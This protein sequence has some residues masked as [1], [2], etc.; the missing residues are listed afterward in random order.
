[1][2]ENT[3]QNLARKLISEESRSTETANSGGRPA[4]RVCEKLRRPLSTLAGAAGFRSLAARALTLAK[5]EDSWLE[6]VTV[7]PDGSFEFTGGIVAQLETSKAAKAGAAVV[8]RLLGL[9]ITFIGEA[10]TIR[11]MHDV[12]PNAALVKL[13]PGG[14]KP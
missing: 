8:A 9:L 7:N 4:F 5:A 13:K 14:D 11:L 2:S 12:W 1:V 6:G 3:A 10:L